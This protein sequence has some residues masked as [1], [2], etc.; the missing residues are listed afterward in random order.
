[1]SGYDLGSWVRKQRIRGKNQELPKNLITK[2]DQIGFVLDPLTHLWNKNF[3]ELRIYKKKNGHCRVST[4]YNATSES[5]LS[6][7]VLKQRHKRQKNE[8]SRDRIDQLDSLGFIWNPFAQLWDQGFSELE[9]YMKENGN[10]LAPVRHKTPSG[11]ALGAWITKQRNNK[12]KLTPERVQLLD[13]IGFSWNI[14]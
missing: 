8:L 12:D 14:K 11:Y 7:W 5:N 4:N 10:C 9:I 1:M 3:D 2:L 13:S 6:R